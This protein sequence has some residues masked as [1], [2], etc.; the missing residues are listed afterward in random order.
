MAH[1]GGAWLLRVLPHAKSDVAKL[2][3]EAEHESLDP[4]SSQAGIQRMTPFYPS[5][6][7]VLDAAKGTLVSRPKRIMRFQ[8]TDRLS[9]S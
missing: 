4:A 9:T 6:C 3:T 7:L 8:R 5:E 1:G 2:G